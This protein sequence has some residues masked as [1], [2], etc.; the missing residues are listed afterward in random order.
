MCTEGDSGH[1]FEMVKDRQ[2]AGTGPQEPANR[3]WDN[4]YRLKRE[5]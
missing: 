4:Q 2:P 5:S 1:Y 3:K